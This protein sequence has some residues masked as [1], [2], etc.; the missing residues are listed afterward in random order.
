M[1]SIPCGCG[2]AGCVT[3]SS[4]RGQ[5]K[6]YRSGACR[7]YAARHRPDVTAFAVQDGTTSDSNAKG[8]TVEASGNE[9]AN[10]DLDRPAVVLV[11]EPEPVSGSGGRAGQEATRQ[12]RPSA[13]DAVSQRD[14][15]L[16]HKW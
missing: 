13:A 15:C 9:P 8:Q 3:A 12:Q 7:M 5:P 10:H 11:P 6:R 14:P 4:E 16:F 2:R 1:T